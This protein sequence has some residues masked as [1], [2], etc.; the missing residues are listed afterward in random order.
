MQAVRF[1]AAKVR[2]ALLEV[3]EKANDA[4]VQTEAQSLAE[5][6]GSYRFTICSVVWYDIFPKFNMSAKHCSLFQY[7]WM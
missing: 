7:S 5:K 1:Q 4:L 3:R 6:V 2:D